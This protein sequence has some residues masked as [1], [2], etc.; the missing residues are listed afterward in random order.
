MQ[1][2]TIH[3]NDCDCEEVMFSEASVYLSVNMITFKCIDAAS[4]F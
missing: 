1:R 2:Q 4:S 3:V